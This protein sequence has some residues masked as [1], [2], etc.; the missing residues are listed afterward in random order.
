[1]TCSA[2]FGLWRMRRC[3][4]FCRPQLYTL[5]HL[6]RPLGSVVQPAE[7]VPEII[8]RQ[9]SAAHSLEVPPPLLAAAQAAAPAVDKDVSAAATAQLPDS[10]EESLE[11]EAAQG[12]SREPDVSE[13]S[14]AQPPSSDDNETADESDA[15]SV[16]AAARAQLPDSDEDSLT[17]DED[18]DTEPESTPARGLDAQPSS[19]AAPE[20]AGAPQAGAS[21]SQPESAS[22]GA[23]G[24]PRWICIDGPV[25]AFV[26]SIS[27]HQLGRS[28]QPLF[29]AQC[30]M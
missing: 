11:G 9:L 10:D 1:V 7:R 23:G 12:S 4:A 29:A 5:S 2:L 8:P 3:V 30:P 22:T 17:E 15:G 25:N 24:K 16:T 27:C 14:R 18:S 13:A 21:A 26:S 19:E 20:S 28:L 6:K